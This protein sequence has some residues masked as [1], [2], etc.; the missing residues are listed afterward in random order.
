MPEC[1]TRPSSSPFETTAPGRAANA[2][3]SCTSRVASSARPSGVST[4]VP[5][6]ST[7]RP[8]TCITSMRPSRFS[9]SARTIGP[10]RDRG[11][12]II[13]PM[14]LRRAVAAHTGPT[15]T[16]ATGPANA[17]SN[18]A[19]RLWAQA[20]AS[21]LRTAG[22]L[23]NVTAWT[24]SSMAA[25]TS[26]SAGR[27]SSGSC[28]RYTGISTTSAPAAR[29]SSATSDT[30]PP[31]RWNATRAPAMPSAS[32]RSRS[33]SRVSVGAR[34]ATSSPAA[35]TAPA[36]LGPRATMRVFRS[37]PTRA[38]PRPWLSAS[39]SQA[40]TPIAVLATRTSGGAA[41]SSSVT[42]SSTGSDTSGSVRMAGPCTTEMP[43]RESSSACSS[44]RRSAVTPTAKPS[45]TAAATRAWSRGTVSGLFRV[46][47]PHITV[48][49]GVPWPQRRAAGDLSRRTAHCL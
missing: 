14:P 39:D 21:R 45:S 9:P 46:A 12:V 23:V 25:S 15:Q 30:S 37:A 31:S 16:A 40:R 47:F 5:R 29:R 28:Q 10:R 8:S 24:R 44:Q 19:S 34:Q 33:S 20:I 7:A 13:R 22:P 17:A 1:H 32:S 11:G 36:A 48:A 6:T 26:R 42:A 18:D 49:L 27:T 3:S 2:R 41:T 35:C 38:S 43:R 4:V